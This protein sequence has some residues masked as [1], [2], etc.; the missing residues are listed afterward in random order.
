[1]KILSIEIA[2][3]VNQ[4]VCE[5]YGGAPGVRDMDRLDAAIER[6]Y[7]GYIEHPLMKAAAIL[8]SIAHD[9]PF[10]DGNKR[11][12]YAL[13]QSLIFSSGFK[14]KMTEDEK[15]ALVMD[16]VNGKDLDALFL[17]IVSKISPVKPS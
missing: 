15:Y 7:S 6:L 9:H 1:M 14:L 11:T 16:A 2:T 4:R 3:A 17:S 5:T 12:G 8:Q 13:M 10:H